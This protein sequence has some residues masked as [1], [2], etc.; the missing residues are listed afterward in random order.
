MTTASTASGRATSHAAC[1][2]CCCGSEGQVGVTLLCMPLATAVLQDC[3]PVTMRALPAG[4]EGYLVGGAVR[5][6]LLGSPPK[7]FDILT[8]AT[9]VQ[10]GTQP[11]LIRHWWLCTTR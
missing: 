7:D 3:P 5:D 8:S 10:A 6:L 11:F 2:P 4:H 9:P 1:G